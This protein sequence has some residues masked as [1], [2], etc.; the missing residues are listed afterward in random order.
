[1]NV[2]NEFGSS[3]VPWRHY[4][5]THLDGYMFVYP[6]GYDH[7]IVWL[8]SI[9]HSVDTTSYNAGIYGLRATDYSPIQ[10]GRLSSQT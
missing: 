4:R 1:M 3:V 10:E 6:M 8:L 5:L 9:E 2:T 7:S